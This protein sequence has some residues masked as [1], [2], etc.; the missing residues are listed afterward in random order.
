MRQQ[1]L[2]RLLILF[3]CLPFVSQA[4][5]EVIYD[6]Q[7]RTMSYRQD[8][9][10]VNKPVVKKG[11]TIVLK[12]ENYNNYLYD[13]EILES[14][15]EKKIGSNSDLF[16]G[17]QSLG[18]QELLN[19][20]PPSPIYDVQS[21]DAQGYYDSQGGEVV[22]LSEEEQ[23]I[24]YLKSQAENQLA[25]INVLDD[26][27]EQTESSIYAYQEREAFRQISMTE[28]N[29]LKYNPHLQPQFIRTQ[30]STILEKALNISANNNI[31]LA[32]ILEKGNETGDLEELLD[33]HQEN[34]IS[35]NEELN[36]L[37]QL[38]GEL[39]NLAPNRADLISLYFSM[40][41]ALATAPQKNEDLEDISLS[42]EDLV[43]AYEEWSLS[44]IMTMWYEYETV[45]ANDFSMTYQSQGQGD[46]TVFNIAFQLKEGVGETDAPPTIQVAPLKVP[47]YGGIK[48]NASV[49]MNFA[50]FFDQPKTYFVRDDEIVGQTGDDFLPI[51]TSFMHFYKQGNRN[52]SLGGSLGVGISLGGGEGIGSTN[53][54]LGPSLFFGQSD[55]FVLNMGL[56]GA[57]T[58]RLSLGYQEGDAFDGFDDFI[59]IQSVYELGYF[60]GLSFNFTN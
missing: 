30:S 38:Q 17:L 11:Q 1:H 41:K 37:G 20:N 59:P 46:V 51:V 52:V 58:N 60:V 53:F 22:D 9:K 3:L 42:I 18:V 10:A 29:K 24:M 40:D 7:S 35:Y 47:V 31:D 33:Q 15:E 45:K 14:Y 44:D 32:K 36:L 27:F 5:L 48:I 25:K 13:V 16:G 6:A 4:Q 28:V 34:Q 23:Q 43:T 56:M 55:R 39:M 26:S 57:K 49:G 21:S 19:S 12:V 54:F 50:R 8:D 2:F